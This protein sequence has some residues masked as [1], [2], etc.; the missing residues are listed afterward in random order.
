MDNHFVIPEED[1]LYW[2]YENEKDKPEPVLI[3]HKRYGSSMK[4][5]NGR[6]QSWLRDGEYLQGPQPVPA[7]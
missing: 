1:G 4:G 2:Y 5:F 6:L 3:D 7:Q